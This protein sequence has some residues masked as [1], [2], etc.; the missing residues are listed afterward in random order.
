M[1]ALSSSEEC[2]IMALS[3]NLNNLTEDEKKTNELMKILE[4]DGVI[5]TLMESLN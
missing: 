2:S 5:D 3:F 4:Q 1:D